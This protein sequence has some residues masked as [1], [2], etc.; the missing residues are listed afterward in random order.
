MR[1]PKTGVYFYEKCLEISRLTNDRRGEMASNHD[2]GLI[3]QSMGEAVAASKYHERHL[4]LATKDAIP[5]EEQTAARELVKVYQKIAEEREG[6]GDHDEAVFFYQKTLESA[7]LA[8]ER[9]SEGLANYRL[10]RAY[11]MLGECHRAVQFLEDYEVICKELDDREG[12]GQ[13]C[14]AMA[15]AYQALSNDEKALTYLKS[16]LDIASETE[17]LVT[18]GEACC[19]LGVIYNKRGEYDKAVDYFE[20]NFEI[21]RTVAS[22]GAAETS[23]VDVS[24]VYL[25]MA[26]GNQMLNQYVN[27]INHDLRA[28]L[29]WKTRRNIP[30]MSSF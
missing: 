22:T 9:Q 12:E 29:S 17:N 7:V 27:V 13:A 25:G 3:Y 26:R 24:R 4:E 5:S 21:A 16:C 18:Q 8:M 1:D 19:A 6:E 28:I 23:H 20:R 15:A 30:G 11:V 14:S 10:G 2:L